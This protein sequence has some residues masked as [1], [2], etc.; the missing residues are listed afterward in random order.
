M[1]LP[2][3]VEEELG[4]LVEVRSPYAGRVR[5][6]KVLGQNERNITAEITLDIRGEK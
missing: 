4:E 6:V 1:R 2:W 3:G 5:R